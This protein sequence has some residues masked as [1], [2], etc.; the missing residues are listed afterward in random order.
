[1]TKQMKETPTIFIELDKTKID[2]NIIKSGEYTTED[3]DI[4][5]KKWKIKKEE[6]EESYDVKTQNKYLGN[7]KKDGFSYSGSLNENFQ[8]DGYGLEVFKNGD[9]FLGQFDS[10]IRNEKGVYY[11]SPIKNEENENSVNIQ[12]ECYLGEW[13]NNLKDKNGIYIWLD[14]QENKYEYNNTNFDAYIGEFEE[15][16]YIRG[17]YLTKL[18]NEYTLYHGNFSKEGKKNDNNGYFFSSKWNK[19]F[20]G[21]FVDDALENGY[22][23]SF[24]EEGENVTEI[25]FCKFNEDG[26][27]N[28]VIEEN[29][30]N[31]EDVE[32]EKKYIAFFR[33]I[34]FEGDYFGKIYSIFYK[35]KNKIDSL[36]D[37]IRILEDE[38]N[39]VE[40]NKILN[41]YNKKNLYKEIE[42]KYFGR[43]I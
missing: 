29:Q 41:K 16:K 15:D 20:H 5:I 40:M 37:M 42:V 14:Q 21:K 31:Q 9:K 34:I 4:C 24:D 35:I 2:G 6:G 12:S 8:R 28:D 13:K 43:E 3:G 26:S 10:D 25:I 23:C 22:L 19:M 17:T 7:L 33:S 11:F 1:M 39:I 27:V 36:E 32:K 38:E 18:N 30:L